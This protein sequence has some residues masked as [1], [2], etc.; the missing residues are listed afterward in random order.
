MFGMPTAQ[1]DIFAVYGKT[2]HPAEGAGRRVERRLPR[3]RELSTPHRPEPEN[4]L[5]GWQAAW[6]G[7]LAVAAA[8]RRPSW[9]LTI[10]GKFAKTIP[11]PRRISWI[12]AALRDF[13][14]F[15]EDVRRRMIRAL[16][17]AAN[18][19]KDERAKPFK[20][21]G[22]GVFEIALQHRGAAFR[23]IYDV[24]ADV[25]VWVAHAFQKK[26]KTGIKTAQADKDLIRER[27]KR[28]K[29]QLG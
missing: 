27:L 25:D 5:A 13:G 29:E 22:S 9:R 19:E 11:M 2:N 23:V 15:P 24:Q 21:Y 20:G 1:R 4:A 16:R 8:H 12:K 14:E 18:G 26:S 3:P 10:L 28:L 7:F 17:F 6:R